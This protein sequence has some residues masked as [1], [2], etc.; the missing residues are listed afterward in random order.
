MTTGCGTSSRSNENGDGGR[1]ASNPDAELADVR[2][3]EDLGPIDVAAPTK[4]VIDLAANERISLCDW[5]ARE[6]GGYGGS[7]PCLEDAGDPGLG[8]PMSVQDCVDVLQIGKWGPNCPLTVQDFM[9]CIAWQAANV[10]NICQAGACKNGTYNVPLP[11]ECMTEDGPLCEGAIN[12]DAQPPA[13]TPDGAPDD[14]AHAAPAD[15]GSTDD[16]SGSLGTDT[17]A[18]A[19]PETDGSGSD[20]AD[21]SQD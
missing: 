11:A 8:A 10:C 5:T 12:S 6:F 9:T 1:D 18:D 19:A 4:R 16:D 21:S 17:G 2:P 13:A 7:L 3:V 20:G 14:A 15:T